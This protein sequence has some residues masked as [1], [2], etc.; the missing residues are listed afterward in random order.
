M[1]P[2]GTNLPKQRVRY[3][4][5]QTD[6]PLAYPRKRPHAPTSGHPVTGDDSNT[7]GHERRS[8]LREAEWDNHLRQAPRGHAEYHHGFEHR[9][10]TQ[11]FSG[12]SLN[13]S[14]L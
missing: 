6:A 5:S 8:R 7:T 12:L 10:Q 2:N 13:H 9:I 3:P 11:W 14:R 4:T 1:A